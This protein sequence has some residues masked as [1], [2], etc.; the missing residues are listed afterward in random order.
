[1]SNPEDMIVLD[2]GERAR[3]AAK[4]F[5]VAV[6]VLRIARA[7]AWRLDPVTAART[8]ADLIRLMF[9]TSSGAA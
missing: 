7:E 3:E 5:A 1:M 9:P 4:E 2:G 6:A 8:E